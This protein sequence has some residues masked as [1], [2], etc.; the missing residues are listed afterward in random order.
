LGV[1]FLEATRDPVRLPTPCR[2]CG[3]SCRGLLV[4]GQELA[5][6]GVFPG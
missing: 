6:A 2:G 4:L 1:Q 5:V 3:T